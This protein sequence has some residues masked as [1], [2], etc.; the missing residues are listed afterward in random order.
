MYIAIDV[1]D[2]CQSTIAFVSASERYVASGV[3]ILATVAALALIDGL[4]AALK[5]SVVVVDYATIVE[6]GILHQG[7]IV[8]VQP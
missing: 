7:D 8:S 1:D 4:P 6:G 2:G 3:P 5:N